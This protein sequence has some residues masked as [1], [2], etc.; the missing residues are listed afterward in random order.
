MYEG[1]RV[2][3]FICQVFFVLLRVYSF[4]C[5][6]QSVSNRFFSA[7]RRSEPCSLIAE[8]AVGSET[9]T[10]DLRVRLP[11]DLCSSTCTS[12]PVCI[13]PESSRRECRCRR[14]QR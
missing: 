10:V 7:L 3:I 6:L 12:R 11:L 5:V 2:V 13:H 4:W 9:H 8:S 14:R 1:G